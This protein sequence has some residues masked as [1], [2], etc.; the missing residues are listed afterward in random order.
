M[1]SFSICIVHIGPLGLYCGTL[2]LSRYI[3]DE[4]ALLFAPKDVKIALRD[5]TNTSGAILDQFVFNP[6]MKRSP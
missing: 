5:Q 3:Y 4:E 6:E 1:K 2:Q